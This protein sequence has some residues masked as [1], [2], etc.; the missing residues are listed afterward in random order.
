MSADGWF[1]VTGIVMALA[2][3]VLGWFVPALIARIPEPEPED[4][5]PT[6]AGTLGEGRPEPLD[7][8]EQSQRPE[9]REGKGQASEKAE[10]PEEPKELYADIAG[11]PGLA[12]K[13]ALASAVAAG[14]VGLKIGWDPL[15]LA[16]VYLVPVGVALAVVDWRTR[17]L[18]TKV[19]AP[20]YLVAGGLTLVAGVVT[21]EW[22]SLVRAA[23]GCVVAFV[24]FFVLWFIYPAGLGFGDVR[25]AGLLGI[26]LGYLGWGELVVGLYAGFLLGGVVGLLLSLLRIVD[27]KGYPFGPFMLIG[28]LL[29]VYLGP[30]VAAWYA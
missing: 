18:P 13:S 27:R 19:I 30:A 11:R 10:E 24:T 26:P 15:L 1:P 23:L 25:L 22:D 6:E 17:L 5:R 29:G 14:L 21:G 20:S 7:E 2:G 12:W 16:W 4:E 3:A 28:A 8:A 9:P